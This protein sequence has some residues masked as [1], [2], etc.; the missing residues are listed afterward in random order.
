MPV[1]IPYE[2]PQ[3]RDEYNRLIAIYPCC[4][5]CGDYGQVD[6]GKRCRPCWR[7][8]TLLAWA[9]DNLDVLRGAGVDFADEP[10]SGIV[11][12]HWIA[13]NPAVAA[14]RRLSHLPTA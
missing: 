3:E 9:L 5:V 1:F 6:E 4:E 10:P 14:R 2:L 7:A 13:P 12:R 11:G 8:T